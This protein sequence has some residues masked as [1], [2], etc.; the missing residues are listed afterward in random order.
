MLLQ[1]F[2]EFWPFITISTCRVKK[3]S[4]EPQTSKNKNLLSSGFENIVENEENIE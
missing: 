4:F 2:I 3:F 1:T